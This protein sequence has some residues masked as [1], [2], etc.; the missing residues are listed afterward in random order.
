MVDD[1]ELND[2]ERPSGKNKLDVG[3]E[4]I[5]NLSAKLVNAQIKSRPK[6]QDAT[7]HEDD[8]DDEAPILAN[9]DLPTLGSVIEKA[10]VV[11]EVL[12]ARDPLAFRCKPIE[13]AAMQAGKKL[14]LVLNK[15]G[16]LPMPGTMFKL[17]DH[18][19]FRSS[20]CPLSDTCPRESIVAWS[21]ELRAQHPTLLFRSASAFLPEGFVPQ[22]AATSMPAS[23][24]KAKA[25]H[26]PSDAQG[27]QSVIKFLTHWAKEKTNN[28]SEPLAVAVVGL[29]NVRLS[30]Y[31]IFPDEP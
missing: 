24:G 10:D 15:I 23:K 3:A 11:V 25:R 18:D 28:K 8:E 29:T 19:Y 7:T 6:P 31:A 22:S 1:P 13:D 4:S 14:L 9:H 20:P 21:K 27:S 30:L 5:A 26:L 17:S 16:A 12:D 2:E